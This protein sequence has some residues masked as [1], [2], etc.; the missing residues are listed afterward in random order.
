[1]SVWLRGHPNIFIPAEKEPNFFNTDDRREVT[2][3]DQYE[4]LF[5]AATGRQRA[6]G[7]ASVWYLS[8]RTAVPNIL[9][10]Q[11]TAKF[12]VMVRNPVEMAPALHAEMVISGHESVRSFYQAWRLQ[13]ERRQG[14]RLPGFG[15]AR[16]R[17]LYGE[18]CS[19]GDQLRRVLALVPAARV[20]TIVFDDLSIEPRQQYRRVLDFLGVCDDGRTDFPVYNDARAP[21]VPGFN[22]LLNLL[23]EAKYRLGVT[24][25]F[26]ILRNIE[27]LN[28][29]RQK[30]RPLSPKVKRA[31]L[32]YF[33]SDIRLLEQLLDR[34]FAHWLE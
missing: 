2:R 29:V 7:E 27:T 6:I 12:V 31:L 17:L 33:T 10:Y 22:R 14:R 24:G 1:M 9:A 20:L 21:L 34:N 13:D 3:L 30:R 5:S 26:G 16:R 32:L 25:G 18:V 4:A 23:G 11:P 28:Q 8:S 19:V 15:W